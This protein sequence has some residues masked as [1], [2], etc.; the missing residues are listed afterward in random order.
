MSGIHQKIIKM[1]LQNGIF[2]AI[3]NVVENAA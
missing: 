2:R 3:I 1:H